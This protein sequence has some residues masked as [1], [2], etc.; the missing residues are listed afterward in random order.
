[1]AYTVS[2]LAKGFVDMNDDPASE[3]ASVGPKIAKIYEDFMAT[4]SAGPLP[5][6]KPA[7]T[8][9]S[10]A[11]IGAFSPLLL[12]PAMP[13]STALQ[14]GILA[15]WGALAA[16]GAYGP[17][18][19]TV[20]PPAGLAA[21]G[22]TLEPILLSNTTS[23]LDKIQSAQLLSSAIMT[24]HVGGVATIQSGPTPVPTPIV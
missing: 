1:M 23:G 22:A 19:V 17:T 18:C 7:I 11:F 20:I 6:L 16:P 15:F 4:S 9:G 10:G 5:L 3:F 14:A 21:L 8:L 2:I 13:F 24:A 12:T